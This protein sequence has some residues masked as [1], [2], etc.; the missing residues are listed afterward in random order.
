LGFP[1]RP[2]SRKNALQLLESAGN[3]TRISILNSAYESSDRRHQ[4]FCGFGRKEDPPAV[5]PGRRVL[6]NQSFQLSF[7]G[8]LKIDFPGSRV[9]S[10]GGLIVVRELDKRLGFGELVQKHLTDSRRAKNSPSPLADLFRQSVGSRL[11]GYED[12]NDTEGLSQDA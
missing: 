4:Y 11:G 12:V 10:E 2:S 5:Y 1:I 8:S 6:R 9:A 7:N 3:Y